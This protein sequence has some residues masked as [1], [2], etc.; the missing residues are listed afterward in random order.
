MKVANILRRW[1]TMDAEKDN[2]AIPNSET[3]NS[4][5]SKIKLRDVLKQKFK[6]GSPKLKRVA[7]FLLVG[8]VCFVLGIGTG[9]AVDTHK[10]KRAN[11]N[12]SEFQSNVPASDSNN[13][14][15]GGQYNGQGNGGTG[16][17]F[18]GQ[19]RGQNREKL[20][21]TNDSNPQSKSGNTN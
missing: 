3:F 21:N 2:I 11:I 7:P 13:I 18:N 16:S 9:R 14:P 19:G 4:D 17:R 8:A 10:V 15:N 6:M 5:L 1:I 12:I 20:P